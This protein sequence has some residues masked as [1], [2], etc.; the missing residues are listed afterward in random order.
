MWSPMSQMIQTGPEDGQNPQI[1]SPA[2]K[3]QALQFQTLDFVTVT[4]VNKIHCGQPK[5]F[6]KVKDI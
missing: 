3:F 6:N 1:F 5:F 4:V 2:K